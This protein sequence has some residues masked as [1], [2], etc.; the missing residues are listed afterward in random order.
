M[1]SRRNGTLYLG[2]TIDLAKRA[3]EHRQGVIGGFTKRYACHL[4]VWYE[5]HEGIA[6]ARH[7][8]RQMKEWRRDWKVKR[9]EEFN[10]T[11]IDLAPSLV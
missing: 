2:S 5:M 11:W 1:A 8:E 7:R 4:L 3:W 10:P 9:I 6:E